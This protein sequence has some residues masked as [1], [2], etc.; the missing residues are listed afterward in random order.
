MRIINK[1]AAL[2]LL[3]LVAPVAGAHTLVE[4]GAD[5]AAGLLHLLFGSHHP[6]ALIGAGVWVAWLIGRRRF[7]H[8][9]Q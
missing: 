3:A 1:L 4:E 6:F 7:G 9:T 2:A 8:A 5:F